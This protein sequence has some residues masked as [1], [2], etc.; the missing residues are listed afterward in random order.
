MEHAHLAIREIALFV[1]LAAD[2]VPLAAAVPK[3]LSVADA[4]VVQFRFNEE[5]S[6]TFDRGAAVVASS[7]LPLF[8]KLSRRL[9]VFAVARRNLCLVARQQ[10]VGRQAGGWEDGTNRDVF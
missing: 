4:V 10:A 7:A 3:P 5:I 1:R 6:S 8:T 2:L 9:L